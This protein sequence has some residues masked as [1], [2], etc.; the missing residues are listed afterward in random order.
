MFH[1]SRRHRVI[2]F[3][4]SW[5]VIFPDVFG[6]IANREFLVFIFI[7]RLKKRLAPVQNV[8]S[9]QQC[10][11]GNR[12]VVK[13]NSFYSKKARQGVNNIIVNKMRRNRKN[14]SIRFILFKDTE[15]IS[16]HGVVKMLAFVCS[17]SGNSSVHHGQN[18]GFNIVKFIQY[19]GG[20]R[21]K[22]GNVNLFWSQAEHRIGITMNNSSIG[23]V[24]FRSRM[25]NPINRQAA[26]LF[27][28]RN[29]GFHVRI[30]GRPN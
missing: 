30:S 24:F 12:G 17:P 8:I 15:P 1:N 28:F 18:N 4:D 11:S 27:Q 16:K 10:S 26:A 19:F 21:G 7:K 3:A 23:T 6:Q 14:N 2:L 25:T 20:R 29:K 9:I 5:F 13:T 22:F